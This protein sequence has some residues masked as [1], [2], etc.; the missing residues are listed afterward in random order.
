MNDN[1][2]EAVLRH[3]QPKGPPENLRAKIFSTAKR[4]FSYGSIVWWTSIAAMLMIS[5]GFNHAANT[6]TN[7]T[8]SMV[9]SSQ[10]RWTP[11]AE[12]AAQM[13][14]GNGWG[15]RYIAFALEMERAAVKPNLKL[16]PL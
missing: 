2:I 11:E 5:I 12:E 1:Q 14:D 10:I 9:G 7:Q 3:Y 8:A 6:I 15:R 13:L 4:K 16:E